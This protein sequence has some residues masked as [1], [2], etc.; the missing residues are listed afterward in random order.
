[1]NL[2]DDPQVLHTLPQLLPLTQAF[3]VKTSAWMLEIDVVV[4]WWG[5]SV[6]ECTNVGPNDLHRH[7]KLRGLFQRIFSPLK[8]PLVASLQQSLESVALCGF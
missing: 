4:E 3:R 1:M 5:C 7:T 6:T 2:I 8:R